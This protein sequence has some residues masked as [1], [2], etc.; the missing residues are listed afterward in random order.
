MQRNNISIC[1]WNHFENKLLEILDYQVFDARIIIK[2]FSSE[3]S[4]GGVGL[5]IETLLEKIR[6]EAIEKSVID[7]RQSSKKYRLLRCSGSDAK[8]QM[9]KI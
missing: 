4:F 1:E 6:P 9:T 3:S 2:T 8:N 7:Y 5:P